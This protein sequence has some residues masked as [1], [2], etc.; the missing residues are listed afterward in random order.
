MMFYVLG[1][2][3]LASSSPPASPVASCSA[4]ASTLTSPAPV[5]PS[6]LC[7][8]RL[9]SELACA[10]RSCAPLRGQERPLPALLLQRSPVV[11]R[12]RARHQHPCPCAPWS[13]VIGPRLSACALA[14]ASRRCRPLPSFSHGTSPPGPAHRSTG[15]RRHLRFARARR[16]FLLVVPAAPAAPSGSRCTLS[17]RRIPL[18]GGVEKSKGK[19]HGRAQAVRKNPR[20]KEKIIIR[21]IRSSRALPL[22]K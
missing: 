12:F 9:S 10:P 20:R 16:S 21:K 22:E 4:L 15:V 8:T 1:Q 17:P 5:A 19:I 7:C 13:T 2:V 3:F 6:P 18:T 14:A 11:T